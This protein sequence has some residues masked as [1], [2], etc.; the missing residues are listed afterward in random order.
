MSHIPISN[1]IPPKQTDGNGKAN[2]S[3][4]KL[5]PKVS[6]CLLGLGIEPTIMHVW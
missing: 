4:D 3:P 6:V 5:D 2:I 1:T